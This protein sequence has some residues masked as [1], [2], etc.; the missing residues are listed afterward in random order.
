MT[1]GLPITIAM[2]SFPYWKAN[3]ANWSTKFDYAYPTGT[4]AAGKQINAGAVGAADVRSGIVA[5]VDGLLVGGPG[6]AVAF[7]ICGA[8]AGSSMN[9]MNQIIKQYISWW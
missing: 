5:A 1:V 6:G 7:G 4:P 3:A 9:L 2:Y 8:A